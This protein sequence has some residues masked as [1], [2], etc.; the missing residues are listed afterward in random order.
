MIR[1]LFVTP[2]LEHPPASGP[3]LRIESSIKVLSRIS[4]LHL[5]SRVDRQRLGGPQA[6]GFYRNLCSG[7]GYAPSAV[8]RQLPEGGVKED[9]G[10][11]IRYAGKH[12]IDIIWFGFGNISHRLMKTIK[13]LRPGLRVICDTDSVWSRF[14]LRELPFEASPERRAQIEEEGHLKE[15]E[16][17]DSVNFCDITTAVSEVDAEYYRGL[18]Q[19]PSRVHIFSNVIDLDNYPPHPPPEG[20]KSPSLYLAGSFYAAT[21]PMA[22]AARWVITEVWPGV[23]RVVPD[24]HLYIIGNGASECL[25]DIQI[26]NVSVMGKV[27]TVLPYLCNASVALVPLMFE[28]GTRFKIMEAGVCNIPIVSTTLGA[29]GIPV[30]SGEHMLIADTPEDFVEA[31][32]RIIQDRELAAHLAKNCR[33]LIEKRYSLEQLSREA[34]NILRYLGI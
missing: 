24:A 27:K 25:S 5:V 12:Q 17:A 2:E 32:V 28:S 10:A 19:D 18:A 26:H 1:I 20:F 21:S 3:T 34:T 13:S 4:E 31:I 9:A 22:R 8:N 6:E 30:I 33:R 29:E 14:V 15:Q 16:E 23:S 11:I 7:F